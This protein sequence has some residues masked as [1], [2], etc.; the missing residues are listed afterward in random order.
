MT[1]AVLYDARPNGIAIITIN[2]PESR[3][4]INLAVRVGLRDAFQR[5]DD[6]PAL[7]SAFEEL[8]PGRQ[9]EYNL[10]FAGAKQ[11]ATRAAR[12][13]KCAQRI[14]DGKGLRDR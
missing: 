6:D 4:A 8:T 11:A 7:R 2:R 3:N 14:L 13:D 5:F 10:Y 1:D 12:V 9:R